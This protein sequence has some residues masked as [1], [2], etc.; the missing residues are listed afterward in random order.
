MNASSPGEGQSSRQEAL[1]EI[2][3]RKMMGSLAAPGIV[4][5]CVHME[6]SCR[7]PESET[8][9]FFSDL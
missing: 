9:C 7:S 4:Q 2:F 5:V 6:A 8:L 1:S 3:V